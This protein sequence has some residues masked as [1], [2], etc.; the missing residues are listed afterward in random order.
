MATSNVDI[1]V[2]PRSPTGH[3]FC[4]DPVQDGLPSANRASPGRASGPRARRLHTLYT[5]QALEQRATERPRHAH[6]ES[7][8]A[9][10]RWGGGAAGRRGGGAAGRRGGGAGS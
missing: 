8:G 3:I 9:L 7:V 1:S 5:I 4:A 2:R 10:E 6:Q